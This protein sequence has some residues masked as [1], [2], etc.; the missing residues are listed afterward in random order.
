MH[1]QLF[2][3]CSLCE[4]SAFYSSTCG[5]TQTKICSSEIWPFWL[6]HYLFVLFSLVLP[7]LGYPKTTG[8]VFLVRAE[9][10]LVATEPF[11]ERIPG[12]SSVRNKATTILSP[13][14][15]SF[16]SWVFSSLLRLSFYSFRFRFILLLFHLLLVFPC[17]LA[18]LIKSCF[19]DLVPLL[20][21][22]PR[23][24]KLIISTA[25]P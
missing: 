2:W 22:V 21:C 5:N 9:F 6:S 25:R 8:V 14:W 15:S 13:A 17:V 18:R 16:S 12:V 10:F 20:C 19:C 4:M 23:N 1:I 7:K 11:L 24:I 3:I